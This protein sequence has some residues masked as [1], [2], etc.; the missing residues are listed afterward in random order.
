MTD[1]IICEYANK[2]TGHT[3]Q[4]SNK[5][6]NAFSNTHFY[7]L[8]YIGNFSKVAQKW[9]RKLMGMYCPKIDIKLVFSTCKVKQLFIVRDFV[10][11]VTTC[12]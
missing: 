11:Q 8:P 10:P 6:S 12:M 1:K 3:R 2:E 7:K 5:T 4:T 9:L